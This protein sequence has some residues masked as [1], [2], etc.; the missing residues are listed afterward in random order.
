MDLKTA[1]DRALLPNAE[2]EA[3]TKEAARLQQRLSLMGKFLESG[4]VT[5]CKILFNALARGPEPAGKANLLKKEDA[6]R[7]AIYCCGSD[8]FELMR[9]RH[10]IDQVRL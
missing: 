7:H 4:F 1:R 9:Q 3:M 2:F 5:K 8:C 6:F 10:L